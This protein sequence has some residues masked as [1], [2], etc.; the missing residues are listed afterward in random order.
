MI[1]L[2]ILFSYI[3][4][5]IFYYNMYRNNDT[6]DI[7]QCKKHIENTIINFKSMNNTNLNLLGKGG[8]GSVY[9]YKSPEC[10]K[11]ALKI[12]SQ[13]NNSFNNELCFLAKCK[14]II[15]LNICPN[16]IYFYSKLVLKQNF[17]T[18]MKINKLNPVAALLE[19]ADGTL[20]DWLSTIHSREEWRSLLFQLLVSTYI[21]KDKFKAYHSDL[22][23]KNILFKKTKASHFIYKTNESTYLVPT[24]GI[25]FM[26]AD[27]GRA[28]D[29]LIINNNILSNIIINNSDLE[30]YAS[31]PNRI[32]VDNII[33]V[34]NINDIIKQ[35]KSTND[36][37]NFVK[38]HINE[39]KRIRDEMKVYPEHVKTKMLDRSIVYYALEKKHIKLDDELVTKLNTNTSCSESKLPPIEIIKNIE[40]MFNMK[41]DILNIIK[42]FTEYIH[43]NI[44]IDI[45]KYPMFNL[46]LNPFT[47]KM[48]LLNIL[49]GNLNG[50]TLFT[51]YNCKYCQNAIDLIEK[52]NLKYKNINL[53]DESKGSNLFNEL[54]CITGQHTVPFIWIKNTFIGGYDDLQKQL[55]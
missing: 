42:D 5:I 30:F 6:I 36:N 46:D 21:I 7:T 37:E 55:I 34:F 8:E 15:D 3:F 54:T 33:K 51:K 50:I 13:Y 9:G 27:F 22:K 53:S 52:Y 28:R 41:G 29:A 35:I 32:A 19:Y 4:N 18:N 10:G 11:I 23:P 47:E 17:K 44:E 43:S 39:Q 16:F 49:S 2:N 31:L 20:A 38:Y 40:N 26:V 24:F 14:L 25:F 48:K 1:D 12:P 45:E